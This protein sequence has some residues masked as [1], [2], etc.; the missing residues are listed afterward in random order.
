M[1]VLRCRVQDL[2][3]RALGGVCG[4]VVPGV[5]VGFPQLLDFTNSSPKLKTL[6][7]NPSRLLDA[8]KEPL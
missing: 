5:F 7:L 2:G 8:W 3:F 4:V 1:Y 6:V